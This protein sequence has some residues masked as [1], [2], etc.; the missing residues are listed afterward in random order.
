MTQIPANNYQDLKWKMLDG[1]L[2]P[3]DELSNEELKTFIKIATSKKDKL[4]SSFEFFSELQSQLNEEIHIRL[5][6]AK[7][8]VLELQEF[9]N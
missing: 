9:D 7:Q 2:K 3:I 4:Y 5:V 1:T 6:K 8:K